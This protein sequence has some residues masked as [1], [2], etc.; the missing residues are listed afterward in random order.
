MR[1]IEILLQGKRAQ[2]GF[3]PPDVQA[4]YDA[5]QKKID[6]Y[7]DKIIMTKPSPNERGFMITQMQQLQQKQKGLFEPTHEIAESKTPLVEINMGELRQNVI[8]QRMVEFLTKKMKAVEDQL[9]NPDLTPEERKQLKAQ[10]D[11]F[12][13]LIIGQYMIENGSEEKY[14]VFDIKTKEKVSGPYANRKRA[15]SAADKKDLEHGAIRYGVRPVKSITEN[16]YSKLDQKKTI[17]DAMTLLDIKERAVVKLRFWEGLTN[18]EIAERFGTTESYIKKIINSAFKKMRGV[19]DP[20]MVDFSGNLHGARRRNV[21]ADPLSADL[22]L[23]PDTPSRM[24]QRF[25]TAESIDTSPV[26]YRWIYTDK[27]DATAYFTVGD[28][29]Y[30]FTAESNSMKEWVIKFAADRENGSGRTG[31]G[32]AP[33]VFSTVVSIIRD[34]ASKY[35]GQINKILFFAA[36]STRTSIYRRIFTVPG[37]DSKENNKGD[38]T[39][40]VLTPKNKKISE[41]VHKVPIT[42]EDFDAVKE[43]MN[44]PIPAAIA[45]IYL[46]DCIDDDAFN[47]EL[48]ILEDAEPARDVRP[49]IAEWFDRVMPDQLFHFRD[50]KKEGDMQ[51]KQGILSPIHG[52][53][54]H[55]YKGTNDPI[56]GDAY[57]FR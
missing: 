18:I 27:H 16:E 2:D 53:D 11:T 36:D 23:D 37:F 34:F 38:S 55:V 1:V 46:Q 30:T 4:K 26:N 24:S 35:A 29:D 52:Y 49:L 45:R 28:V 22:K 3:L 41:A 17:N 50:D 54:P 44:F 20:D 9:K 48:E 57:G 6:F 14:E 10:F 43:L 56:T 33:Q 40:F 13:D 12:E 31:T 39:T 5:L 7:T 42:T 25:R 21:G 8:R 47:D 15:R 19:I 51:Q 32:N